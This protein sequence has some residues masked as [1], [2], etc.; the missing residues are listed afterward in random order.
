MQHFFV[1]REHE[2]QAFVNF[3]TR[4]LPHLKAGYGPA[5]ERNNFA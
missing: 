4:F 2:T 5:C 1:A 3:W